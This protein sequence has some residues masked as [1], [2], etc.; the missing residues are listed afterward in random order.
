MT[1]WKQKSN[2]LLDKEPMLGLYGYEPQLWGRPK[3]KDGVRND[4]VTRSRV[5]FKKLY[6]V[7]LPP[8]W[9]MHADG[10]PVT[11]A[12]RLICEA[13]GSDLVPPPLNSSMSTRIVDGV[14]VDFT[15]P[16]VILQTLK[17]VSK[18]SAGQYA[19]R[20]FVSVSMSLESILPFGSAKITYAGYRSEVQTWVRIDLIVMFMHG[21]FDAKSHVDLGSSAKFEGYFYPTVTPAFLQQHGIDFDSCTLASS[22]LKEIILG[23]RGPWWAPYSVL[24]SDVNAIL[25]DQIGG[26]NNTVF[27]TKLIEFY[28]A[29]GLSIPPAR[30]DTKCSQA[31]KIPPKPNRVVPGLELPIPAA[32]A[33]SSL[34]PPVAALSHNVQPDPPPGL[35][36]P[37]ASRQT[38]ID[39][40]VAERLF[41]KL[42]LLAGS[43][44]LEELPDPPPGPSLRGGLPLSEVAAPSPC[45]DDVPDWD[46]NEPVLETK[47][48]PESELEDDPALEQRLY[49][50][51]L[52]EV[53]GV[54]VEEN[55][56]KAMAAAGWDCS[57]KA[58][59]ISHKDNP[60]KVI[61]EIVHA[62]FLEHNRLCMQSNS[63]KDM[64]HNRIAL[65]QAMEM[66]WSHRGPK[67]NYDPQLR[68]AGV[69]HTEKRE[70][71]QKCGY[72]ER[73]RLQQYEVPKREGYVKELLDRSTHIRA[74]FTHL[75]NLCRTSRDVFA[76][77]SVADINVTLL[78]RLVY[79]DEARVGVR[80]AHVI[81]NLAS[82]WQEVR[83]S[84]CCVAVGYEPQ[85]VEL[86]GTFAQAMHYAGFIILSWGR[87]D[88]ETQPPAT[89]NIVS[90]F[91]P[92][93][94][95]SLPWFAKNFGFKTVEDKD[96]NGKT[97]STICLR[98]SSIADWPAKSHWNVFDQKP[99]SCQA[100]IR[101]L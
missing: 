101:R 63:I 60:A 13:Y 99:R 53:W 61:A 22:R 12:Y 56:A 69:Y 83:D 1:A 33:S 73:Q 67:R 88:D 75:F 17:H 36:L 92:P 62:L 46:F 70:L 59:A 40:P 4:N 82:H 10:T 79:L 91:P 15:D 39:A 64:F 11:H 6:G 77:L 31:S 19:E 5:A 8:W 38:I 68:V 34:A 35:S 65:D 95:R 9:P 18:I 23:P 27:G 72:S 49:L 90:N 14:T 30:Q 66:E 51:E 2:N 93:G 44:D 55:A 48:E 20:P 71:M 52:K 26:Y 98:R 45:P 50:E 80:G 57:R 97:F 41:P 21:H 87:W 24:I 37:P 78:L 28:A 7:E 47:P 76:D 58:R 86:R 85:R 84:E 94:M 25:D 74:L 43:F 89:I 81:R 100:I 29:R 3:P 16:A 96:H 42:P 32:A 54:M